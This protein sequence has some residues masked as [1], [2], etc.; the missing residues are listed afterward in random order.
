[1]KPPLLISPKCLSRLPLAAKLAKLLAQVATVAVFS[2]A[3]RAADDGFTPLFNGRDLT[4]WDGK[5]GW[6]RVEDG[7]ITAESTPD[8]PC[9]KHNYLIWRGGEPGDF[10]LRFE[11]RIT[12]GNSGVQIRSREVPDWDMRGY[13]A[14]IEDGKQWTGALFEH[15]RGGVALRGEKVTIAPD[16][17]RKVERFADAAALQQHIHAQDWNAYRVVAQGPEIQLFINDVKTAHAVDR[18]KGRAAASGLIGLQMHPGPPMKVQFRNLRMKQLAP[19]AAALPPEKITV[20]PGFKV[21][22]LYSPLKE[23]EGSWVSLCAD[24]QGHLFASGQYDEGLVRITLPAAGDATNAI[25]VE[26]LPVEL[27][28]AQ[29]LCWAFDSLYALVTKNARSASGLYRVRDTNSDGIPDKTELLHPLEGGGDHGWHGVL[30][31]PDGKSL[32]VVA[33]N[34][35]HPPQLASS[36]VPPHWSEDHLLPRLPDAGGHMRGVLAPGG[37]IYRVSPDGRDWEMFANGFRNTY[38]AAFD[39]HGDLFTYDADMEWDLGTPWYRP[40]RICQVTS[41]AEFGWRNGAGK[42][43]AYQPDSLPGI[44]NLGPGSPTGVTFGY[45]TKFPQRYREALFA[46]DWTFG[47]VHAVHLHPAGAACRG[48]DE[49]FLSGVPLPVVDLVAHPTD[50][51]L[52]F[53]TGGWRIQTG[54]YRVTWTG[55]KSGDT[56]PEA[57]P[58]DDPRATRRMLES[59][60]GRRDPAAVASLWPH[61]GSSD[62]FLRFAARVALEW[63][64]P[65][66]WRNQALTEKDPTRRLEALLALVRVSAK[67]EFHRKPDDPKPDPELSGRVLS[68]LGELQWSQLATEQRL[69]LL[70][71]FTLCF[72]RLGHPDE[73]AR[74][75]LAAQME[76]WFPAGNRAL[77]S[78]LCQML[79]HLQSPRIASL[80]LPLIRSAPTQEEQLDYIKSLRM[81]RVGWTPELRSEYFTWFNRAAGYRGGAS[82]TGF[83]NMI[84][85][86]A[87]ATLTEAERAALKSI[88]EAPPPESPLASFGAALAK[89]TSFTEWT[90]E[91]LAPALQADRGKRDLERGRRMFGATGCFQC[92]RFAGEG[93]AV[94]PDLTQLAGRFSRREMLE[95][96]LEPS[97]TVSDLYGNIIITRRNH[98][99]LVGRIVY[100]TNNDSV[101]VNPDMFNPAATVTVDR[102]DVVSIEPSPVSPMP[103]GLLNLLTQDEILDLLAFLESGREAV[104]APPQQ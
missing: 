7:T 21:D 37:V 95:S 100:H 75:R 11:Y 23:T 101:M 77:N 104:S 86:D 17:H 39:R 32:C 63:Q 34:N 33:G 57:E 45:G 99:K 8:K 12:G 102:K 3:S 36:K 31:W 38:D 98:E 41:G 82:F 73:A 84:K 60:H 43:P 92:H 24:P 26:K 22:L 44:L 27:S 30:P 55:D 74:A 54:L 14:D 61:L 25:H 66:Q 42:W 18:Q 69:A 29:G 52:Y 78:E 90:V 93:G 87:L 28:S 9:D 5:P 83:V 35:T 72:T 67:D 6:W 16:G 20:P 97:K 85:T 56:K 68:S 71:A 40:T 4:G 47:R 62:R 15:E 64:D 76:P 96:I 91:K 19:T 89:R 81:L 2:A 53:I 48:E 51:A 1:M 10:E 46:A 49:V 88:L 103:G 58:A 70:R 80:A 79:V 13:Q 50:G 65:A 59:F 94:G